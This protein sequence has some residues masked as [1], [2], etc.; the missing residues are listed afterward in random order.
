MKST[1]VKLVAALVYNAM[2]VAQSEAAAQVGW[3]PED[4]SPAKFFPK[5]AV[6]CHL[7]VQEQHWARQFHRRSRAHPQLTR[8]R[9]WARTEAVTVEVE[10]RS[11]HRRRRRFCAARRH[12]K[13]LAHV[14]GGRRLLARLS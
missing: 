6:A 4:I 9:R 7:H 12:W 14:R 5:V 11:E 8:R 10:P 1:V 2:R 3:A 13:S